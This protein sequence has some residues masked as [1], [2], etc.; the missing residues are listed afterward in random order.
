MGSMTTATARGVSCSKDCWVLIST[1]DSQQP[2]PGWEWYQP[3]T[4][5]GLHIGDK[6]S[7]MNRWGL[8]DSTF[9]SASAYPS[10]WFEIRGQRPQR[11]HLFRFA[12]LRRHPPHE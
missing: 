11:K 4:V 6:H 9:Q 8:A 1:L 2:K 3:T 12:A 10:F 7:F 5:S